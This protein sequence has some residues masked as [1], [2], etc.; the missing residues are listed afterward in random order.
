M[1]QIDGKITGSISAP[2]GLRGSLSSQGTLN[3]GLSLPLGGEQNY[4]RLSHKPHIN[5]EELI[6]DK[7]IE[8]LGVA[9]L[10]NLEIK[11]IF[12]TVFK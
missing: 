5:G 9:T 7:S 4:E 8:E 3:G 10:T 11:S 2:A 1:P 12:D 6:G